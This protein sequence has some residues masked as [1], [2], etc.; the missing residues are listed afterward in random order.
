MVLYPDPSHFSLRGWGS[1]LGVKGRVFVLLCFLTIWI[2][3]Y[4]HIEI[5]TLLLR[6]PPFHCAATDVTPPGVMRISGGK[7]SSSVLTLST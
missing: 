6:S 3:I 2:Y 1:S 4:T 5:H 7:M